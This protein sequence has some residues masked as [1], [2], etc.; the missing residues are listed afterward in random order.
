MQAE[1]FQLKL[2][3][4]AAIK[5]ALVAKDPLFHEGHGAAAEDKKEFFLL[6][7]MVD[8]GLQH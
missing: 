7:I 6:K 2:S 5:R 8:V 1:G 3:S 4:S